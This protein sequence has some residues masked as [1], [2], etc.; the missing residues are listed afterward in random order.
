MGVLS[1]AYR[2]NTLAA[3]REC[4]EQ[5]VG[6]IEIDI[7][8]LAGDDFIVTHDRRLEA[9]TSGSGS[10]GAVTP[11]AVRAAR[12]RHDPSDR[13][14]LLSEV[15]ALARDAG[16]EIQLDLKDWRPMSRERIDALL[17][18]IAPVHDRV[19]VSTG[20]DWN[21][22]LLH[23]ADPS[24]AI[25]FDPGLYIDC[26][27][28]ESSVFL[29][30]ATGAYGY[31]DDHPLAFGA[32][33]SPAAYLE[34]RTAMLVLQVP[35][36]REWFVNYRMV[37]QMLDDGFDVAAW[38]RARGIETNVWTLDTNREGAIDAFTRLSALDIARVTT[39]TTRAWE[40]AFSRGPA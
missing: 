14:A 33:E 37:L 27:T 9:S 11:D 22:R 17:R 4:F 36:A 7:H 5:G 26:K 13:P 38:L 34:A 12:F 21:L 35:A 8:S 30:R 23:E 16:T 20:Q 19:I 2:P 31:R 28:E 29:P 24:L 1:G 15:A 25:G 32:T 18:A 10:V 39:N 3:I 6:R 40:A